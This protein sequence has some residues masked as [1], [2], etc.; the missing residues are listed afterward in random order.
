MFKKVEYLPY[1]LLCVW[2]VKKNVKHVFVCVILFL[3]CFKYWNWSRDIEDA[4]YFLYRCF[5]SW[6]SQQSCSRRKIGGWGIICRFCKSKIFCGIEALLHVL[7]LK[8][9][10]YFPY[11]ILYAHTEYLGVVYTIWARTWQTLSLG[12][13]A[14]WDLNQPAM[15]KRL[16]WNLLVASLDM[17]LSKK[18]KKK[19][20]RW[21]RLH[22]L[23]YAFVVR[24]SPKM[25]FLALR[26][27]WAS[28]FHSIQ[29]M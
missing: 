11:S 17:I 26:P 2:W 19:T 7:S 22:M 4:Y 6:S 16:V 23:V 18:Q 3:Y 10:R 24:K 1:Q 25:N 20:L 29:F 21:Y 5:A 8:G 12:I 15:L 28:A 27:I 14:E 13:L 9:S